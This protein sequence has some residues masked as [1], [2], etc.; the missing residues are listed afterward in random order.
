MHLKICR[1]WFAFILR[2]VLYFHN[3]FSTV[4]A[5]YPRKKR[6]NGAE[7]VLSLRLKALPNLAVQYNYTSIMYTI[8]R[9]VCS[10][11][12]TYSLDSRKKRVHCYPIIVFSL[13]P[14]TDRRSEWV[15]ASPLYIFS[16]EP[17]L[18]M[19][20]ELLH[21]YSII[22]FS[23]GHCRGKRNWVMGIGYIATPLYFFFLEPMLDS[24]TEWVHCY[25]IIYL[26]RGNG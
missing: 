2:L 17:S 19:A 7:F 4:G 11:S 14:M 24:S 20:E 5:A 26:D 16:P 6:C 15:I 13:E 3:S 9:S 10:S 1:E 22:Y 8:P 12:S 25:S 23:Q 18:D 21:C